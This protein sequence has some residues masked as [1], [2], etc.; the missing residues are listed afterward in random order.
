M[1]EMWVRS[2]GGEDPL[3]KK[4]ATHSQYFCLENSMDRG[5]WRATI[6]GVTMSQTLFSDWA[7]NIISDVKLNSWSSPWI[8]LNWCTK[9]S[10]TFTVFPYK[11]TYMQSYHF[12]C[13]SER[14]ESYPWNSFFFYTPYIVFQE[15]LLTP[16]VKYI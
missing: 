13:S 7:P 8:Q 10:P 5:V 16:Y 12:S 11:L 14:T 9:K 1:W 3:V 15:T 4:M 2:L 6:H